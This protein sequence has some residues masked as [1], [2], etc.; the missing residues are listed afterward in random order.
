ME[1]RTGLGLIPRS[2]KRCGGML[3]SGRVSGF[4]LHKKTGGG[5]IKDEGDKKDREWEELQISTVLTSA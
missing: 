4:L 1:G 3:S 5:Q 2:W